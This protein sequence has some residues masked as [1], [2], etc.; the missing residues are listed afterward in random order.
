MRQ[1]LRADAYSAAFNS[2]GVMH[3]GQHSCT[4]RKTELQ[5][6]TASP[7]SDFSGKNHGSDVHAMQAVGGDWFGVWLGSAAT[8]SVTPN[9]DGGVYQSADLKVAAGTV[10]NRPTFLLCKGAGVMGGSWARNILSLCVVVLTVSWGCGGYWWFRYG[11][12]CPCS[13]TS[14]SITTAR[15][16][17]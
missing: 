3:F 8:A 9:A 6:F 4:N 16:G 11:D 17:R 15:T 10:V 2:A 14:R 13:T 1:A 12:V 5:I 7:L